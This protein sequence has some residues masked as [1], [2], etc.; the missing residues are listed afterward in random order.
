MIV[1]LFII[2]FLENKDLY[3]FRTYKYFWKPIFLLHGKSYFENRENVFLNFYPNKP[4][5]IFHN[6]VSSALCEI[7]FVRCAIN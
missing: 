3:S 2:D 7:S 6:G 1:Y 4:H 5:F